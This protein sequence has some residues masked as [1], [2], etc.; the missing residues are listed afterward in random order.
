MRT[1]TS[2]SLHSCI[3]KDTPESHLLVVAPESDRHL[4]RCVRHAMAD[5]TFWD[6]S[7]IPDSRQTPVLLPLDAPGRPEGKD[8]FPVA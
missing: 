7:L 1:R 3:P 5:L 8:Y 6:K 2:L 4:H